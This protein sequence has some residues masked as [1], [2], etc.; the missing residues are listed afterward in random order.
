MNSLNEANYTKVVI[1]PTNN[2]G[3]FTVSQLIT[4]DTQLIIFDLSHGKFTE[5]KSYYTDNW[6]VI[7]P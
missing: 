6:K 2:G 1:S 5:P 3:T 4:P 7:I